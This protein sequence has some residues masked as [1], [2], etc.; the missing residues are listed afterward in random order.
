MQAVVKTPHIRLEGDLL[1]DKLIKYLRRCFGEVEVVEDENDELVEV[2]QSEWYKNIKAQMTPGDNLKIYR[3]LH[4]LT[5]EQLGQKLGPK[6]HRQH[7]SNMER[8]H[9]PIS[10]NIAVRLAQ[11]FDVTLEKFIFLQPQA[12]I[13]RRTYQAKHAKKRAS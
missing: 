5:Q 10:K 9:R 12:D 7:V 1:P 6:F 3:E 11:L 4:G 13:E 2:T 8:G